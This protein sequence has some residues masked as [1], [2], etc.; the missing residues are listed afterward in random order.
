VKMVLVNVDI[1]TIDNYAISL[2][3]RNGH[4]KIVKYFKNGT[5]KC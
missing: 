1:T 4:S 2:A 3:A 5:S